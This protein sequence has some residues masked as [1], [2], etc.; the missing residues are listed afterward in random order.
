MD[1]LHIFPTTLEHQS[2]L[3]KEIEYVLENGI[4]ERVTVLGLKHNQQPVVE[5]RRDGLTVMRVATTLRNLRAEGREPKTRILQRLLAVYGLIQYSLAAVRVARTSKFAYISCHYNTFLPLATFVARTAGA[6]LVYL[7][8]E[9]ETERSGLSGLR[10]RLEKRIESLFIGQ[11]EHTVVVSRRIERWYRERYGVTAIGTVRN[12]P[13]MAAVKSPLQPISTLRTRFGIPDSAIVYI[14]LGMLDS[15]RAIG[16]ILDAFAEIEC[17]KA[18]LILMGYGEPA[19]RRKVEEY[20]KVK[21]NIDF[22][23]AVPM[24]QVIPCAAQADV[25]LCLST[26]DCLSHTYSM[27]NKFFEYINAGLPIVVSSNL[28]LLTED[29]RDYNLG[30]SVHVS[31]L[32][33]LLECI[34]VEEIERRHRSVSRFASSCYWENDAAYFWKVYGQQ[35]VVTP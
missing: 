31:E 14:Y 5:E 18:H 32:K 13:S 25:G 33:S 19:I 8:H 29:I 24:D 10:K 9:L 6:K 17:T 22:L 26:S 30:W 21:R 15:S 16:P 4:A 3:F 35:S 1:I 20:S 28:I 12:M 11:V 7:P 27:P 2:R 34:D 23:D